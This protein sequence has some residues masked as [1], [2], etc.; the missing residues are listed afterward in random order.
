MRPELESEKFKKLHQIGRIHWE[1]FIEEI[2][3]S[4]VPLEFMVASVRKGDTLDEA[5][6]R[7]F[8]NS[9]RT[10]FAAA[11]A[12]AYANTMASVRNWEKAAED[13]RRVERLIADARFLLA[14]IE[15]RPPT[16]DEV[17]TG[18]IVLVEKERKL[19]DRMEEALFIAQCQ[20][21]AMA[22]MEIATQPPPIRKL[23]GFFRRRTTKR[24]LENARHFVEEFFAD[25][26]NRANIVLMASIRK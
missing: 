17:E 26:Q 14:K 18:I 24:D 10:C 12:V 4:N 7:I 6:K 15:S 16:S 5:A 21:G 22:M 25:P 2:P 23:L 9:F 13:V 1:R 3:R 8:G 20:C 19:C 11:Y